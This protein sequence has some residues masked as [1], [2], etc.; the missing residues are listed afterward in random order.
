MTLKVEPVAATAKKATKRDTRRPRSS[1]NGAERKPTTLPSRVRDRDSLRFAIA[2]TALG[3]VLVA[4]SS[5]G[6]VAIL[7]CEDPWAAFATRGP[8]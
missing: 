1:S 4:G 3:I 7:L 5:K 8:T 2:P 6:I